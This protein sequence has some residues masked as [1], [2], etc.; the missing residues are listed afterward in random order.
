MTCPQGHPQCLAPK[1]FQ[2]TGAWMAALER[3]YGPVVA[4]RAARLRA[5]GLAR[6]GGK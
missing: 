6:K 1:C 2:G 4:A 5:E 3:L